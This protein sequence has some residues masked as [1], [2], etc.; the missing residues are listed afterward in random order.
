MN[1]RYPIYIPSKGRYDSRITIKE[2]DRLG[3][4]YYVVIEPQEFDLYA[5]YV[6]ESR[7]LV[8]GHSNVPDGLVRSRN[9]IWNHA[10]EN[11]FK[12]HWQLDDNIN[13]FWRLNN[14]VRIRVADGTIF[15][16]IEDFTERYENV[17][18]SGMQ[19]F[20]FC[21][22]RMSWPPFVTNTRVYSIHLLCNETK[23]NGELLYFRG[24]YNDD[25]DLSLR[26]L[27]AGYC[28]ILFNAF[29]GQKAT[30]MTVKG[31]NVPIYVGDG[32]LK[33]A[34][35][36]VDW[37]PDVTV[38]TRKWGRAQHQVDYSGFKKNKLIRK[39][40]WNYSGINNYGMELVEIKKPAQPKKPFKPFNM[41]DYWKKQGF[42]RDPRADIQAL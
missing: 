9:W 12:R 17:P 15:R 13:S 6:D 30:T 33:M 20:M 27:K 24:P 37:H 23:L 36:L 11:G 41:E 10:R 39:P 5:Q 42:K 14:N 25:T 26:I 21:P 3:L 2:L 18:H 19:Y 7:L 8:P 35:A 40:G 28:T 29:L 38:I 32:R 31:G 16:C 1:P 22:D 4:Y 34:Q